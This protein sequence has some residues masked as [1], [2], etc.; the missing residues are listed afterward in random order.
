MRPT[1]RPLPF[2]VC[3]NSGLALGA[4]RPVADVGAPRLEGIEV[5][6]GGNFAVETLARQPDLEIVGLGG[7]EPGVAGAEQHAAIRQ[8]QRLKNLFG[9]AGQPLVLG[10]GLLG[11]RELDQLDLLKLVLANDAARVL[12]RRARL[13][14]KAGRVSRERD[15]QPRLVEDFVAIEIGDGNL[16]CRN[17]PVV[18]VLILAARSGFG[19][20]IGAAE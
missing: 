15:G 20:G 16:G 19:V 9:V 13:G 5:G 8:P 17:Q 12:A 2:S 14:A 3:T 11:A 7:G 18:A 4:G 6:A 10:V 1:A